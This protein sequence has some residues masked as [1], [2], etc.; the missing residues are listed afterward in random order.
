MTIQLT[1]AMRLAIAE[2]QDA[3]Y[4]V[5]LV[6]PEIHPYHKCFYC[7]DLRAI[8]FQACKPSGATP[9]SDTNKPIFCWE[10]QWYVVHDT[11]SFVCPHCVDTS[12]YRMFL[13]DDSGLEM[14]HREWKI[15]FIKD[16]EGKKQAYQAAL[17]IEMEASPTGFFLFYGKHGTGKSGVL[18]SLVAHCIYHDIPARYVRAADLLSELRSTYN[19]QSQSE[20]SLLDRYHHYRLLAIDELDVISNT[21][22]AESQLRNLID[23]RYENRMFQATL[24]A[25]NALPDEIWPYLSSRCEDGVRILVSG[26]SL[27]GGKE[28]KDED[29]W[30]WQR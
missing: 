6:Q 12:H 2:K 21:P 24:M 22:W 3:G 1:E 27:R 19:D 11:F 17:M 13:W 7:H 30:W 10:N 26:E 14:H 16:R 18:R 9:P 23:K 20:Q 25:T 15:D 4:F 8:H 29:E 28:T 5:R